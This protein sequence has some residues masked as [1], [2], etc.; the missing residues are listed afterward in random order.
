MFEPLLR[1]AP[2]YLPYMSPV[3]R[4]RRE[5]KAASATETGNL[6][7]FK[8]KVPTVYLFTHTVPVYVRYL[9]YCTYLPCHPWRGASVSVCKCTTPTV[10]IKVTSRPI[11]EAILPRYCMYVSCSR[12]DYHY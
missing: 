11:P 7:T 2:S 4:V 9:R 10:E 5:I 12:R 6:T 3:P 8:G 1:H